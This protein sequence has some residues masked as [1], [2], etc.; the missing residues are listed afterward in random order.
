ME[1]KVIKASVIG[2]EFEAVR[3][4]ETE[5]YLFQRS[6]ARA[7]NIPETSLR[8][9]L[10]SKWLKDRLGKAPDR[11][12]VKIGNATYSLLFP[13]VFSLMCQYWAAKN[14]PEAIALATAMQTE[15]LERAFD[16]AEGIQK[17]Q[18]EYQ[19]D[20]TKL[21]EQI[22]AACMQSFA[23]LLVIEVEQDVQDPEAHHQRYRAVK[24][25][26]YQAYDQLPTEDQSEVS[27]LTGVERRKAHAELNRIAAEAYNRR[28]AQ[29]ARAIEQRLKAW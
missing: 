29:E 7:L 5:R 6:A 15:T 24:A 16:H 10:T 12:K 2:I 9:F 26:F 28:L 11:A 14:K 4:S 3:I 20:T 17:T 27:R 1:P 18:E 25:E 23:K 21:Y 19:E 8:D 22:K 13:E